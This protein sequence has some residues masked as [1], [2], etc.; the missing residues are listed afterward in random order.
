MIKETD[1]KVFN[2][3][4]NL[5]K[6]LG[7]CWKKKKKKFWLFGQVNLGLHNDHSVRALP[8]FLRFYTYNYTRFNLYDDLTWV[9]RQPGVM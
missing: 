9:F 7:R 5:G 8:A 1:T 4:R 3:I 6:L 2:N